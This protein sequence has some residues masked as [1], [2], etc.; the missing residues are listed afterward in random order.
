MIVAPDTIAAALDRLF[1]LASAAPDVAM[2]RH[3]PGVHDEIGFE[4]A[5]G[6]R[7]PDPQH[8]PAPDPRAEMV[9]SD[10]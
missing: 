1:D 4:R 3:L 9:A 10:G 5:P 7:D 2:S 8:H 6:H